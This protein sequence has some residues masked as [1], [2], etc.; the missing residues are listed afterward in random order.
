MKD[1]MKC[2]AHGCETQAKWAI[3]YPRQS[4]R[5]W[6]CRQDAQ[7]AVKMNKGKVVRKPRNETLFPKA[8]NSIVRPLKAVSLRPNQPGTK[9]RYVHGLRQGQPSRD[10][11]TMENVTTPKKGKP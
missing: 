1:I 8:M 4:A 10:R 5:I 7:S 2:N 3:Q 9:G 6:Y 11:R